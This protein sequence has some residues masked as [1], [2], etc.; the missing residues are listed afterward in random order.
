MKA[1]KLICLSIVTLLI[2]CDN[3]E[4]KRQKTEKELSS[5][6]KVTEDK[7]SRLPEN[8]NE[9]IN[10][11][12]MPDTTGQRLEELKKIGETKDTIPDFPIDTISLEHFW[13]NFQNNIRNNNK[14]KVIEVLEFP[15]HAIFFVTFQF[16]YDCDTLKFMRNEDKYA[17][18]DIDN[19][20]VME[21]YNFM[22]CNTLK[23]IILQTSTKD[24]LKD[25]IRYK[26]RPGLI[27]MFYPKDY[28]EISCPNDHNLQFYIRYENNRWHIGIGG[29]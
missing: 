25:G 23:E 14:D 22:F 20:N 4:N 19:N 3:G 9:I 10:I 21:Y 13:N 16:A 8:R 11:E 29:L 24:L 17:D 12:H 26:N 2:A 1:I 18:F 28:R 7:K 27:F 15:V 5:D 6:T